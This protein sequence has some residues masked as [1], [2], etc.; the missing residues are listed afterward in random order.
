[1]AS[2]PEHPT[3]KDLQTYMDA[4]CQERGWT[5]DSWSEKFLL[6]SEEVGELAKAMRKARGLYQEKAKQRQIELAEEFADVL[7]Y[8]LDLANY[9]QV[10]LEQAFREKEAMNEKRIW[11]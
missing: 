3:L 8:L 6:F 1:M 10:D 7:S 2:L 9:F 4:V 11:E 5:K